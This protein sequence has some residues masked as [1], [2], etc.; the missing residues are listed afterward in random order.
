MTNYDTEGDR[1]VT[2]Y[3]DRGDLKDL[4][5]GGFSLEIQLLDKITY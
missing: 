3:D 4:K 5:V 1:G 2:N